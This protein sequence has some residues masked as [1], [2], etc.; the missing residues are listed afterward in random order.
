[1]GGNGGEGGHKCPKTRLNKSIK[2]YY[3]MDL[4]KK[5]SNI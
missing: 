4:V 1:M 2:T 3:K 5:Q